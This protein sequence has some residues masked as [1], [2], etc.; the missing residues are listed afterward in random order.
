MYESRGIEINIYT[1]HVLLRAV[2]SA[3]CYSNTACKWKIVA[4]VKIHAHTMKKNCG[5]KELKRKFEELD[6]LKTSHQLQVTALQLSDDKHDK[7]DHFL[8]WE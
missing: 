8:T 7:R 4:V 1:H 2:S 6:W 5:C 3:T